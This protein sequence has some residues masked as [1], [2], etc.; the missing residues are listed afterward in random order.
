MKNQISKIKNRQ[1][2]RKI[3]TRAKVWGTK[4]R[5]RLSVFRSN[6][7]IYAQLIDDLQ[8]KTLI[9]V[10]EKEIKGKTTEKM[11]KQDRA[12]QLGLY[13]AQK[14]TVKKIKKVVFDRG[15]YAYKGSV[16]VLAEGAR[17]GGLEF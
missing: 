13:L 1:A 14:A 5:P 4:E 17:E 9:G 7:Y 8:K 10:S 3:R 2:R 15:G 16:K 6:K 12:R 11:S